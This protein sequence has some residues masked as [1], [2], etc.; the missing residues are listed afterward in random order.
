MRFFF[1]DSAVRSFVASAGAL[2]LGSLTSLAV[3]GPTCTDKPPSAWRDAATFQAELRAKGYTIDK[4]KTTKG[5]C[6]EIY[7]KDAAGKRVEIYFDP[8]DGRIVK[9]ERR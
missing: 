4:F 1:F 9:E 7:G 5:Q 2:L 6:Y 8:V 3:A